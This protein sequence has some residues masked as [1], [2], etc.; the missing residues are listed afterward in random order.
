MIWA[1]GR[2]GVFGNRISG[3]VDDVWSMDRRNDT[4]F[5]VMT[6]ILAMSSG[7]MVGLAKD[8]I[9]ARDVKA[10]RQRGAARKR[11][12][13]T[14]NLCSATQEAITMSLQYKNRCKE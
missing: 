3:A 5:L 7:P 13:R 14:V 2:R 11:L 12:S 6:E 1:I 8:M 9:K 10:M 4:D